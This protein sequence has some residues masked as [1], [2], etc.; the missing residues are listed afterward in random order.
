MVL[1]RED[2]MNIADSIEVGCGSIDYE[3][4]GELL[5]V[6]YEYSVD[7]YAEDDTNA[8]VKT[9]SYLSADAGCFNADGDEVECNFDE[10]EVRRLVA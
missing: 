3:K 6:N 10:E 9:G 5:I 2:Y 7:G 8:F 1:T 4:G